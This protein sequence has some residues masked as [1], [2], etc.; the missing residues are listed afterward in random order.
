MINSGVDRGHRYRLSAVEWMLRVAGR[1]GLTVPQRDFAIALDKQSAFARLT[2]SDAHSVTAA[3]A[4]DLLDHDE[5]A[6]AL[7]RRL[8]TLL[9]GGTGATW[10]DPQ[11]VYQTLAIAVQIAAINR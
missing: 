3:I 10:E 5:P 1:E 2:Q 4:A 8:R 7:Q 9:T 6:E 11:A